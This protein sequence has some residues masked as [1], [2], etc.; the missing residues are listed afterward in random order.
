MKAL[1]RT[2]L[3]S[4]ALAAPALSFAQSVQAPITRAE[5]RADLIRLEQAGYQPGRGDDANY[6]RNIQAAEAKVQAQDAASAGQAA[7]SAQPQDQSPQQTG[8]TMH[9][10]TGQPRVDAVR[11]PFFYGA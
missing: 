11:D 3:L 1:V 2:V 7:A 6:P 8:A 5:V 10:G 9:A 4:C